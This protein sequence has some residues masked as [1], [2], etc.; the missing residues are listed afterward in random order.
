MKLKLYV[1]TGGCSL[2]IG[3]ECIIV[4]CK[5]I[6]CQNIFENDDYHFE[7]SMVIDHVSRM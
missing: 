2:V 3:T 5:E 6:T 7:G 4:T 1:S